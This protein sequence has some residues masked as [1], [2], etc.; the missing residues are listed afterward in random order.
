M[1]EQLL[2]IATKLKNDES[3]QNNKSEVKVQILDQK[4]QNAIVEVTMA[5]DL[6]EMACQ[7]INGKKMICQ[8]LEIIKIFDEEEEDKFDKKLRDD[9]VYNLL[10]S[11]IISALHLIRVFKLMT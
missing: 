9:C 8:S 3:T 10:T 11:L 5:R 4:I 6:H 7:L 1:R 2:Q